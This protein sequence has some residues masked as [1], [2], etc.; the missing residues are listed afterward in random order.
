[1][2][3]KPIP[4][5]ER[6]RQLLDYDPETGKLTWKERSPSDFPD[7]R[8]HSPECAAGMFNR[9]Y[10]G[11]EA[12]TA[13]EKSGHHQGVVEQVHLLAHRVIWALVHGEWP[14]QDIDH[15]DHNSGNNRIH[16]LR[17]ASHAENMRNQRLP[18]NNA[19]GVM[20][21]NWSKSKSKWRAR[22]KFEGKEIHVGY[23]DH[24]EA[25]ANAV[26][27]AREKFGFHTNHGDAA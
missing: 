7:G 8:K 13:R 3:R 22:L 19:S 9:R 12:F 1:M 24:R 17:M 25:A 23:F 10:A 20:G 5:P 26:A 27:S 2:A 21:V 6:L 14:T 16:N 15:I 4:S 11:N 18:K